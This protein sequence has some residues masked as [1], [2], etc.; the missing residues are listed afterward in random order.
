[1]EDSAQLLERMVTVV[2]DG[3][4]EL[5]DHF[6]EVPLSYYSDAQFAAHERDLFLTQP[7]ALLSSNEIA[8][9]HDFHVRNASGRSILFTRDGEGKAHAFLNYCRHR[10]AE[11]ATGCGN[12]KR[13]MCPYHGWN[14]NSKG[15]LIATPLANRNAALDYS[16][17]GLVELPSEERHG[18][19]WVV[20]TPGHPIDVAAHLGEVDDQIASLRIDRMTYHSSLA[21]QPLEANWKCVSEGLVEG[22]HIPFVHAATFGT[23]PQ[24]AGVDLATYERFGPHL[25]FSLPIFA[26]ADISR[27]ETSPR[28]EANLRRS[29]AQ[30]WMISP[31]LV[32]YEELYGLIYGDLEPGPTVNSSLFRY[33][34]LSPVSEAPSP[35]LPSP[36]QMAARDALAVLEDAPVWAGCGRGIAAG[37][38][39]AV[40]IGRNEKGVQIFHE[41][42]A[43]QTG[44]RGLRYLDS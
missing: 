4:P 15:E 20:L 31:G 41:A 27:V 19:V 28:D 3:L 7:R 6:M 2:R 14:Y 29:V 25:R 23:N 11:P 22:L 33:G 40:L 9:P 18:L 1:M 21:H 43:E 26:A 34:W 12:A 32:I 17:R 30:G 8:D 16:R 36:E 39:D 37:G 5:A 35:D 24:A 44:Y 42:L 38:H 13:H 10:G